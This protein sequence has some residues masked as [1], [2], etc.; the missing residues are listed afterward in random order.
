LAGKRRSRARHSARRSAVIASFS[1]SVIFVAVSVLAAFSR[2]AEE[3]EEEKASA[4]PFGFFAFVFVAKWR[5]VATNASATGAHAVNTLAAL[6]SSFQSSPST[7]PSSPPPP[8]P[9]P[10]V[11]VAAASSRASSAASAAT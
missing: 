2:V 1:D 11:T 9:P 4:S 5:A 7:P 3:E 10:M 8:P 6:A